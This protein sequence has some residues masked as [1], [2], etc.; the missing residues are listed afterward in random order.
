M[1]ST[2]VNSMDPNTDSI[3]EDVY[4]LKLASPAQPVNTTTNQETI[5]IKYEEI[6][7]QVTNVQVQQVQQVWNVGI[8]IVEQ[9]AVNDHRF[10]YPSEKLPKKSGQPSSKA[11]GALQG[12]KSSPQNKS[13]PKVKVTGYKEGPAIVIASCVVEDEPYK[14]HP[15]C[16]VGRNCTQGVCRIEV[17][18]END[19]TATFEKIGIECVTNKKIPESLDRCQRNKIDP[20]NQGFSHMEDKKYLKDLDM[21][22][23]RLCFQVFIPGAKPGD[24]IAGPTVVSDVVKDKRVHE[25]LKI[26]DISDN[27]ATVKGNKKIIMFTT[28]VNKDDIEVRFAFD[29]NGKSYDLVGNV[30]DV[31]KQA[32]LSFTSPVFPDQQL[33]EDVQAKVYLL[34]KSDKVK[35]APEDFVFRPNRPI[36]TAPKRTK[37]QTRAVPQNQDGNDD[38]T[39]KIEAP[40]RRQHPCDVGGSVTTNESFTDQ[41]NRGATNVITANDIMNLSL[42]PQIQ[43]RN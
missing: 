39:G 38:S 16:I 11:V 43:V 20:F 7:P 34:R 24:Y 26:I 19:M 29:H 9:P 36:K 42:S 22:S 13:Y 23:L 41:I 8:E 31:H 2:D 6:P 33:T 30:T 12:A 28:K 40:P 18:P 21:N 4:E 17:D 15:N 35:S 37:Q 5:E 32:G 1:A 3:I 10:R 25:R 14:V 27:F